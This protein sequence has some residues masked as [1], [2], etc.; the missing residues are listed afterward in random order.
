MSVLWLAASDYSRDYYVVKFPREDPIAVEKLKFE[1]DVVKRIAHPHVVRYVD[2]G[3]YGSLPFLVLEYLP[4]GDLESVIRGV[5]ME[6]GKARSVIAQT[7]LGL[8]YLHSMN[9]VHRDVKPKNLLSDGRGSFKLI[10]LGTCTFYNRAG[11]REAIISPGGYTAPEQYRYLSSPQSDV[12]SAGATLFFLLT[13]QHPLVALPG[14][15]DARPPKPPDPAIYNRDVSPEMRGV[16]A[17]AMAWDPTERFLTAREMLEA[18]E[19]TYRPRAREAGRPVLEVM[20]KVIEVDRPILRFGRLEKRGEMTGVYRE[21]D[22]VKGGWVHVEKYGD[23]IEVRVHD[24]Y[25]WISR[26]HFEIFEKGGK[27]FIR[28][29][30]S[31]NRT[32]IRVK[33]EVKEIWAGYKVEGKPF[34]LS[35]NA[36]IYVA[37]GSSLSSPPYITLSFRLGR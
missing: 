1:I 9:I 19:G 32:A 31:L 7:L 12:W 21:E 36:L 27:W 22:G 18:V 37:Y 29:L 23:V 13:G 35:D 11:R 24:P 5:P 20:G 25:N 2:D 28:D 3:V 34:E 26:R 33:G 4:G 17:K 8:D 6:E 14:Y 15:P 10:D 16:V 30:G